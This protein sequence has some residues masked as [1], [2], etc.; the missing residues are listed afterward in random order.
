MVNQPLYL[1]SQW[2]LSVTAVLSVGFNYLP[3]D[4]EYASATV[5]DGTRRVRRVRD[6]RHSRVCV[7]ADRD[8]PVDTD[9]VRHCHDSRDHHWILTI[10]RELLRLDVCLGLASG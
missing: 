9:P 6:I 2:S 8:R 7:S 10:S 4:G 3:T 1:L 5:T